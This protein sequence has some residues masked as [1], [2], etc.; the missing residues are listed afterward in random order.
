MALL[1]YYQE[2]ALDGSHGRVVS[3]TRSE[4][5]RLLR[6]STDTIGRREAELIAA[7]AI[8]REISSDRQRSSVILLG[9][10]AT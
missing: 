4:V 3:W 9:T 2:Y 10:I 6:V 8:R 5:A 7:G 1:A